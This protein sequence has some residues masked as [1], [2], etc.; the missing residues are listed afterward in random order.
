[1]KHLVIAAYGTFLGVKEGMLEVRTDKT[2]RRLVPLNR[3]Q[4]VAIAKRGVSISSDL[5]ENFS[6]RGIKLFFLDFRGTAQAHLIGNVRHGDVTSR[7]HQ[8]DFCRGE[9]IE[10]AKTIIQAKVK[11]QRAVLNYFAKYHKAEK[12]SSG[13]AVL[14]VML[15][16]IASATNLE[17]LLGYEGYGAKVYFQSLREA[18]LFSST[19][20]GR[21]GRGS[22]EVNNSMLNIGYAVLSSYVL[23]AV[24]NAGLEPYLGV[25]HSMRPGKMSLVLDIMEEYRAWV[26]DRAVI[27]LRSQSEG[28]TI[29]ADDLKKALINEIQKTCEKYYPYKK[30][31]QKL[32]NIIQRQVYCLNGHFRGEKK[33]KAYTFKW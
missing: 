24:E 19:F 25:L 2:N 6:N 4:S 31:K 8:Y 30:K 32:A 18:G 14:S 11:N 17:K 27:K 22:V 9:T 23:S 16:D 33:Y 10:L 29:L 20:E 28:K 15:A 3:L 21:E 26:V 7:M 12:L 13:I 5:V 1:M